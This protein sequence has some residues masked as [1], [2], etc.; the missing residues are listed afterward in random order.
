MIYDIFMFNDEI[1]LLE[2]RLNHHSFVDKFIIIESTKTYTGKNKPLYFYE[3]KYRFKEFENKIIH[4]AV[5]F[6]FSGCSAWEFEHMQR[7]ILKG[8]NL[9]K[10]DD[11]IIYSDC[12]E[13]IKED[14]FSK[15][16]KHQDVYHLQ[17]DLFFYYVNLKLSRQ[18]NVHESYHLNSCFKNKFHMAKIIKPRFLNTITHAYEIRQHQI[19]NPY[20]LIE[21][22]GWHFSNLGTPE[23][24]YNRL[25]SISHA[26][27][28]IFKNITLESLQENLKN[29]KDPLGRP[30]VRFEVINDSE[31]PKYLIK[32]KE[33]FK[34]YFYAG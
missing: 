33:R 22:A 5:D 6:P 20:P 29:L 27:E 24:N 31:L 7:D 28:N 21:N 3:N 23:R 14:V 12:D 9:F 1:D 30:G 19:S 11:W 8:L 13:L 25:M 34:E 4:I 32:N 15:L 16:S 10:H 18:N 17:M 26:E 2:I